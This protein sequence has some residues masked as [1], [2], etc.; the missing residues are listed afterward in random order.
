M[1]KGT[2]TG[3]YDRNNKEIRP[4]EIGP[5][6]EFLTQLTETENIIFIITLFSSF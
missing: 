1:K 5:V 4:Y 6:N 2:G 3:I